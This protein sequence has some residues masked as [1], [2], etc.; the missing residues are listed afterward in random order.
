MHMCD[1]T[2]PSLISWRVCAGDEVPAP[3]P[4]VAPVAPVAPVSP[5]TAP[6]AEPTAPVSEPTAPTGGE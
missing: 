3:T 6:V 5:P 2:P 1:L 4:E